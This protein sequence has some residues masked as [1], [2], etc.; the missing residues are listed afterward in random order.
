M[1]NLIEVKRLLAKEG[2]C[3]A[4]GAQAATA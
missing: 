2:R 1:E 3:V 4:D